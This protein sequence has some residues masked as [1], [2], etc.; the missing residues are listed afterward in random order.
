[1]EVAPAFALLLCV[2]LR[3][4]LAERRHFEESNSTNADDPVDYKDPCKAGTLLICI[5]FKF[6]F[7]FLL[8]ISFLKYAFVRG[9][10][11]QE[12]SDS[13]QLKKDLEMQIANVHKDRANHF[14]VKLK[15]YYYLN[16]MNL[17]IM[18]FN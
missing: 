1:M 2:S 12:A 7:L 5:F 15:L 11:G 8:P 13:E 6:S 4:S 18:S 16:D 9:D 3:V 14:I 10:R 17:Y